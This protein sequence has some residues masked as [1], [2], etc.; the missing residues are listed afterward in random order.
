MMEQTMSDSKPILLVE[1]DF[2]DTMA[3]KRVLK[4]LN[5][6]NDL[7][8]TLN[9]EDAL[10]YLRDQNSKVPCLILLDLNMP[11]MNGIEFLRVIKRDDRLKGIPVVVLT[12]SNDEQDMKRS[13]ELGAAAY[14][15][16]AFGYREFREKIRIIEMYLARP[17]STREAEVAQF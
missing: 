17:Q 13:F 2:V 5:T 10:A 9:G 16:K 3:V 1:D 6:A 8:C 12:T 15:V 11:K 4:E 14:I 7:V